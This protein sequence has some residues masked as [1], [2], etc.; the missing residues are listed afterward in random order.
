M[1]A[2][3]VV[4]LMILLLAFTPSSQ[5]SI[6]TIEPNEFTPSQGYFT[7][8]RNWTIQIVFVNYDQDLIDETILLDGLPEQRAHDAD[9]TIMT[10]NFE[11]Q[12]AYANETYTNTVRQLL[13]DNSVNGTDT[14]TQ[15]D[16][17]ALYYHKNNI[18]D[19]QTI[20]SPRDGR[21]IDGV[22]VEDWLAENPAV[23]PP[24]LG[25]MFYLFNFSEFDNADHSLEHWYDYHP[26]DPD[27]GEEQD[28]FRLEWDN[29]LN[30]D[31]VFQYPAFG[32]RENI[33]VLDTSADQWYLRW[34]RIW[35]SDP[36]YTNEFEHCTKDL[37]DKTAELDLSTQAG[38]DALNVYLSDYIYDPAAYLFAPRSPMGYQHNPTQYANSGY[39]KSLVI[40]M[41]VADGVSVESLEWVTNAEQQKANLEELLPFIEWEVDVEFIDIDDYPDWV[42]LF[43][44]YA[45]V[46]D[47]QTIVDGYAMFA[48]IENQMKP[49]YV[50]VFDEN[51][52]V[53]GVV[54]IK[55]DMEM[56]VY[57]RQY[58]GLGGG[59]TTVIWKAW[60]RYYRPDGVT[61][62]GGIS[63]VQLHETMHA[64]GLGHTWKPQHYVGDF[65]YSPMGYY[66]R[67]NETS[68]FDQNWVQGTYLDQMTG[69]MTTRFEDLREGV[70]TDSR[71]E[72]QLAEQKTI[73]ALELADEYYEHMDW[74]GCYQALLD[75]DDWS[76]RMML[77]RVDAA[78]PDIFDWVLEG[79]HPTQ[80]EFTVW[81][82]VLDDRAGIENVTV[83]VMVG[84]SETLYLC[85]YS[86]GNY[87]I[88][89]EGVPVDVNVRIWVEAFDWGM[90]VAVSDEIIFG[91]PD[92]PPSPILGMVIAG[93]AI[94]GIVAVI[95]VAAVFIK[96]RGPV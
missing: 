75:A 72:T 60:D 36:P 58:T 32:G 55:Q 2:Q 45:E 88:V 43:W 86:G 17:D 34:A 23:T 80:G 31:V 14:G 22:I 18:D 91:G 94:A 76:T 15:L 11:Y 27:T 1:R 83:H 21:M 24:D 52:A 54:F 62:K 48:A 59:G 64:I 38:I 50:D 9:P 51:I 68:T 13:L 42:E 66:G 10:Y 6:S 78:P 47:G 40:C 61:P 33:F 46:I 28:W 96:R 77:S 85:D 49:Q 37:E 69:D 93:L 71:A 35:W 5:N 25:Y 16:S 92:F 65:S 12:I 26:T 8:E 79:Q 20:F 95:I 29:A 67:F 87:S 90:N 30:Q 53:F 7:I 44:D 81:A 74:M 70:S 19:P 4:G 3:I 41:D 73:R 56:H 57:G 84:S 39:L 89:A 63:M 82:T